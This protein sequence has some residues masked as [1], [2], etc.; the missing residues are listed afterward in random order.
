MAALATDEV[1]LF[2]GFRLDPQTGGLFRADENG[3]LVP[4]AIGSR[5][6][7][8]LSRLVRRH[9]DL[10]S[11]DE[12]MTAVWPG[13]VVEDSNL[14]TQ[15]LALRR[16]LDR[17]RSNGSCIQ[18]VSGRGY[19]FVAAVTHPAAEA[20]SGGSPS[21]GDAQHAEDGAPERVAP[22]P[23]SSLPIPVPH[24]AC[25]ARGAITA[26]AGAALVI[27]AGAWW[28]W[29]ATKSSPTPAVAVATPISQL[30]VA[31]RMSIVVLPFTNLSNDPDQQYF[32][33][34]LTD[35]LR[36]DLSRLPGMFVISRNSAFT[37]RDKPV[38]AKQI[39]RELGVRYV[40]EGSARRSGNQL[41][42]N[43]QLDD[44]ETDAHLWAER[45]DRDTSDLFALQNEIT[46][47]IAIALN[48]E[49]VDAEA[50]RPTDRPDALDYVLRGRVAFNKL[51]TRESYTEAISLFARIG[52]G[53]RFCRCAEL[54]GT[55]APEP[56]AGFWE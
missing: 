31:P 39:G 50:A 41:R 1:F 28:L 6:L 26:T 43:T 37:Y 30:L 17:G 11:K 40:L 34:G 49:L 47:R 8:L 9:G 51:P 42:V 55:C 54:A 18:T 23:A 15:I 12:I 46:S 19:R 2:E 56:G 35:D 52:A 14:P 21:H 25:T 48:L 33:D 32:A 5:A 3:V 10:V 16:V 45:F 44:A 4:V 36:T 53:P 13:M 22:L 20:R 27:A 29:P 7:D 38:V 24:R